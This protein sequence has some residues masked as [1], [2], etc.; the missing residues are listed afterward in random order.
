VLSGLEMQHCTFTPRINTNSRHIMREVSGGKEEPLHLRYLAEQDASRL[1][2]QQLTDQTQ[3][4]A[5]KELTHKPRTN[6]AGRPARELKGGIVEDMARREDARLERQQK[7]AA[8]EERL[9]RQEET[10]TP[11]LH[12]PRVPDGAHWNGDADYRSGVATPGSGRGSEAPAF[13]RLYALSAEKKAKPRPA[14]AAAARPARKLSVGAQEVPDAPPAE[15]RF[16]AIGSA[17]VSVRA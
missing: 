3:R 14:S 4:E 6:G 13:E 1:R 7:R 17:V 16:A 2:R 8:E 10:F 12:K 15:A 9:N 11:N 5:G